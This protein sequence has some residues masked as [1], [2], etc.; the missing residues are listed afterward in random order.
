MAYQE[1]W[2]LYDTHFDGLLATVKLNEGVEN[3]VCHPKYM[4][5]MSIAVPLN[6]A[7][8]GGFPYPEENQLLDE[9]EALL[10]DKL[11][12]HQISVFAAV[13]TA[14]GFRLYILYTYIPDFCKKVIEETD[15][16]WVY[17][18]ISSSLQED[19]NWE[20]IESLL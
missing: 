8:A 15:R 20:M 18:S 10:R 9:L 12:N 17:H 14:D 19:K 7:D 2:E 13:V 11:E 3:Y 5:Q 1:S 4:Y 6:N 16:V